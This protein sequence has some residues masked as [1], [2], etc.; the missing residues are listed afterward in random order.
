MPF[1]PLELCEEEPAVKFLT[2]WILIIT[3]L[4]CCLI[5]PLNP[6]IS[7]KLVVGF[8]RFRFNLFFFF[9][10][11]LRM[12]FPGQG[13][14]PSHLLC[15]GGNAGSFDPLCQAWIESVVKHSRD[16]ANPFFPQ[17]ELLNLFLMAPFHM[18]CTF[19]SGST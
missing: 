11:S 5:C 15:S 18:C 4:L 9:G 2:V 7:Y 10:C 17:W 19:L 16:S 1:S 3:S 8:I 12:D 14:Y 13:S 6:H